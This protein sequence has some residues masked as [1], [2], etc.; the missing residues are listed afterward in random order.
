[1]DINFIDGQLFNIVGKFLSC[2]V[3]VWMVFQFFDTKYIRTYRSR[4]FYVGL[5]IVCCLLNLAVYL[6]DSALVNIS[7]WMI[8]VLLVSKEFYYD[9]RSGKVK[10][11]LINI[12][13]LLADSTC[14]AIGG[15]IS[16]HCHKTYRY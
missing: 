7:F 14:E 11:Y 5:K 9:E 10:Y 2:V 1:M 8:M 15:Y 6:I 12:V 4:M 13:F 16:R 3:S